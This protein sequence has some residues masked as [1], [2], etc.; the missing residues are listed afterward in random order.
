MPRPVAVLIALLMIDLSA[1][2]SAQILPK[3]EA[4]QALVGAR[5][6][7]CS[8]PWSADADWDADEP[9][10]KTATQNFE[11]HI[12]GIDTLA[13]KARIIGKG[14]AEDLIAIRG[15]DLLT[16]LERVPAGPVH[17]TAVYAW[18]DRAGRFKAVHS[19]HT[20]IAGPVPSQSYG[21]CQV[22]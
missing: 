4:L 3:P 19:R 16:F 18:R 7:K 17:V 10:V 12:D 20:A 21:F 5:S 15:S 2:T 11:F 22:W 14:G 9:Q 1:S 8:F 6:L 13:G